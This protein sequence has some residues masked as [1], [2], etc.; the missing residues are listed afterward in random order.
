MKQFIKATCILIVMILWSKNSIAQTGTIKGNVIDKQSETTLIG[1]TIELLNSDKKTGVTTDI[2]GRFRLDNIPIGRHTIRISFIGFDTITIPNIIVTSGKDAIIAIK[3]IESYGNLNEIVIASTTSKNRPKNK[4]AAIS[5]R[6]FSVEEVGRYSGGRGDVARLASNFAGVSA[7]NDSRNDIVIRGNS[8]TGLLWRLEGIPIPSPNHFSTTGTTGSPVSALNPNMLDNSDF[9]TSAFPAEYGNALGGVFDLGFRKGN[10]DDYEYTLQMGAFTGLEAMAEGPL[11]KKGGAFLVAGRYSL[12]GLIGQGTGTSA[13]PNYKDISFNID[14]GESKLGKFSLFGILGS[15][16]IDFIGEDTKEDDLFTFKDEDSFVTS[17]FGVVGLKHRAIVGEKSYFKTI[18]SRSFSANKYD[19]DKYYN[20][21]T[22]QER[23]IQFI[24]ADNN[25]TRMIFST[26]FNTKISNKTTLRTGVLFEN[27]NL[28][29]LLK[30]REEQFDTDNNRDPELKTF[31][32][33]EES[34][35][36]VQPYVQGQ[37]RLTG[38]LTLNAGLHG[39]YSSLNEQ[40]VLEPRASVNWKIAPKHSLSFG[41]GIHHQS[42]P[43]PL[44]FLNENINGDMVQTNKNLDFVQSD[45]FVLG[46]DVRL[47][48]NWRAKAEIYYQDITNAAVDSSPSSY[49]SLTEG[50]NFRFSTDHL[51]MVNEGTGFNS[52]IELTLEKFFNKGYY[53]LLTTSIFDSKYKGSDGVERNSPFNNKYVLNILAG[54]EF[55]IGKSKKDVF[56]IDTK[57]TAAGGRHYTPV[58]LARSQQAGFQI[59][60][61]DLAFSEQSDRYMKWDLKFGVRFNSK[62]KKRSHQFYVDLQ[63]VTGNK[64]IFERRYNRL[65]NDI[66]KVYQIGFF[67]DVG[68]RFQ[69]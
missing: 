59:L 47:A 38:K 4:M 64:N 26:L 57:F 24:K 27:F 18:I 41:Y 35:S 46:Y 5:A 69:F 55:K 58:D 66:N 48:K 65:T 2:N 3:L 40:F 63:N 34:F 44:L 23:K 20:L 28:E 32:N 6:Q 12:I 8:P 1:A 9:I 22:P 61:E 36:I 39:Q 50:A 25:E 29:S 7:P 33:S 67:P 17:E 52:G 68:Y 11:G 13:L 31:R 30:S 60:Q 15:S 49:S 54:R 45:H 56:F 16:S 19:R 62:V 14:F 51:S 21:D 42:V 53:G 37:F 10:T 43:I